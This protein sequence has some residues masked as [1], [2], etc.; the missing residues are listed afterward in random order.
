MTKRQASKSA[1]RAGNGVLR[2][3]LCLFGLFFVNLL[4]G[5]GN[6]ALHWGLPHLDGVGEFLLLGAASTM[7]ILAA[8][9][10]E[11]AEKDNSE[12]YSKEA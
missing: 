9:K 3:A 8:L 12:S 4:V 1:R 2:I 10:Q 11:E 6:V 5:K 7:L